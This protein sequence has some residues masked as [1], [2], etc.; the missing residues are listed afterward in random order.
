MKNY[1]VNILA[2][3][4]GWDLKSQSKKAIAKINAGNDR[5]EEAR[6]VL[7]RTQATALAEGQ[8]ALASLKTAAATAAT[9]EQEAEKAR[10]QQV[11]EF[12][13]E[14]AAEVAA[15]REKL[16]LLQVK[17]AGKKDVLTSAL[18]EDRK[19]AASQAAAAE[20]AEEE[21]AALLA[22]L[23]VDVDAQNGLNEASEK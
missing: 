7:A 1:L 4:F 21:I 5:I 18:A 23:Q 19:E 6:Q 16:R 9:T 17:R 20:A 13:A 2:A 11:T 8:A 10:Q 14:T 3:I 12:D 15:L 22:A